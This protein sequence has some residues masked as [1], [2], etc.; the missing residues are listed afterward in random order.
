MDGLVLLDGLRR[1]WQ[2]DALPE[3]FGTHAYATAK[4]AV[5]AL[6][7]TAAG[8]FVAIPALGLHHFFRSR[9]TM[10]SI[11]LEEE[12]NRLLARWFMEP[13]A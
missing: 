10:H 6:T 3:L 11:A 4:G 9:T 8:L 7:T 2:N 13:E 5:A 12:M 1:D